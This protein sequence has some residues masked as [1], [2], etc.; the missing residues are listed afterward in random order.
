MK[1]DDIIKWQYLVNAVGDANCIQINRI[2]DKNLDVEE[3]YHYCPYYTNWLHPKSQFKSL[4]VDFGYSNKALYKADIEC[5][6]QHAD[7][8]LLSHYHYD[9][10]RGLEDIDNNSLCIEKLYYPYISNILDEDGS[11]TGEQWSRNDLQAKIIRLYQFSNAINAKFYG[12]GYSLTNLLKQKNIFEDFDSLPIYSGMSIFD[13]NYEVIWPLQNLKVTDT[14][15]SKLSNGI[16]KIEN[17]L[18]Q[19]QYLFKLW[20]TFN[21]KC[22]IDNKTQISQNLDGS[23]YLIAMSDIDNDE[24]ENMAITIQKLIKK[25]LTN[26]FSVCL[27][28]KDEFLFLGDLE[29]EEIERCLK[30]LQEK[31]NGDKIKVKYFITPHHG[32][33]NHYWAEIGNYVEPEFVISSNGRRHIKK[34]AQE[35]NDLGVQSHCTAIKGTFNSLS[36]PY[37]L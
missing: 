26:R 11:D 18:K 34:Y 25:E 35:Y 21:R 2:K 28:K 37:E 22:E 9:H 30:E 19:N 36:I 31:L 5:M 8:F 12:M 32:T 14:I 20:E 13:C 15:V 27:F 16:K 29:K 6:A 3:K 24:Y 7:E 17:I 10:Y 33:Q 23:F 4:L 1:K